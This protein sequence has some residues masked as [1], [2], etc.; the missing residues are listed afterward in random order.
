MPRDG[1]FSFG[2][3]EVDGE[4]AIAGFGAE[5]PVREQGL[6]EGSAIG[7]AAGDHGLAAKRAQRSRGDSETRSSEKRGPSSR[8]T[9]LLAAGALSLLAVALVHL[10][11][12]AIDGSGS[13]RPGPSGATESRTA[14]EPGRAPAVSGP[15]E[16]IGASREHNA[17]RERARHHRAQTRRRARRRRQHAALRRQRRAEA[18]QAE[19]QAPPVAEAPEPAYEAPAPTYSEPPP[20]PP[21]P[22]PRSHPAEGGSSSAEFAL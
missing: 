19:S 3:E 12:S 1:Y 17:E 15:V 16:Q 6:H 5:L 7:G 10:V 14:K 9:H 13:S 22:A 8:R 2:D 21:E 4:A 11:V 18:Q 20:P